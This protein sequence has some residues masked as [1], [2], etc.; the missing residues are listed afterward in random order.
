[1]ITLGT[2]I[3]LFIAFPFPTTVHVFAGA[4]TGLIVWT[5]VSWARIVFSLS[6]ASLR[7]SPKGLA[8]PRGS[9]AYFITLIVSSV[10]ILYWLTLGLVPRQEEVPPIGHADGSPAKYFIAANLYNNEE[11][12]PRWSREMVKLAQHRE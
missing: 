1:V 12:L 7:G 4:S 8:L 2:G 6:L 3:G 5:L 11:I 9:P 10:L